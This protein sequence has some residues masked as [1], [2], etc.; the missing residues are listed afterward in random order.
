VLGCCLS[1]EVDPPP[2]HS[3]AIRPEAGPGWR[4]PGREPRWLL[5]YDNAL[6]PRDPRSAPGT[7]PTANPA[8]PSYK[9]PR[10]STDLMGVSRSG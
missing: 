8:L 2:G 6:N 10:H 3:R 4:A 7:W 1:F 9:R 5:V